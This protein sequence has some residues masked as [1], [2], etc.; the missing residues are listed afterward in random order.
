MRIAIVTA[1]SNQA[2]LQRD[3]QLLARFL[4]A[5]GHEVTGVA[6][7]GAVPTRTFDL[8]IFLEVVP[9]RFLEIA[10]RAWVVPNPEWWDGTALLPRFELV[11]CKTRDCE[12]I[13]R[14]LVGG[15]A[16]FTGFIS[17]DMHEPAVP[18]ERFFLH[19]AGA[20]RT[21]GTV[22]VLEAWK[23]IGDK[24]RLVVVGA[25]NL[26]REAMRDGLR[27]VSFC[28][29]LREDEYRRLQNAATFHLCC[30]EY[31]GWGHSLHE[32]L[33]V[34][35]VIATTRAPPMS[36]IAGVACFVEPIRQSTQRL[37]T[38]SVVDAAG[39][40]AAAE[41]M[42]ALADGD[43]VQARDC[44]RAAF[45]ETQADFAVRLARLLIDR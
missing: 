43:L 20:S 27:S 5:R 1:L 32:A 12:R 42:L 23:Q 29:R 45:R 35:A 7:R 34:G 26:R 28:N 4:A 33:S 18:R 16:V 10:R 38:M 37:A 17:E 22:A 39:V 8:A 13:F 25:A 30:S 9:E 19:A 24:A 41:E 3:Y 40:L 2:G 14:P 44:T 21:K 36:E 15:R 31:E 11:L 6:W